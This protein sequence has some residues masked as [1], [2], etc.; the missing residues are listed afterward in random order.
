MKVQA[1]R[2]LGD[3]SHGRKPKNIFQNHV[4]NWNTQEN[5]GEKFWYAKKKS[6]FENRWD[7]FHL[8][9]DK[10]LNVKIFFSKI[11]F[12]MIL[13][14]SNLVFQNGS[15]GFFL[16]FSPS[17][18]SMHVCE[19]DRDIFVKVLQVSEFWAFFITIF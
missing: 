2:R 16:D 11:N 4:E 15:G 9:Q 7:Y 14:S 18:R 17:V 5:I 19:K 13:H 6:V 8:D 3:R 12:L 1:Y 10:I